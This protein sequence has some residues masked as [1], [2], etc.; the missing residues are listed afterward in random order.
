MDD[1]RQKEKKQANQ[2]PAEQDAT[3]VKDSKQ[4]NQQKTRIQEKANTPEETRIQGK[5]GTQEKTRVQEKTSK[6]ETPSSSDSAAYR[7]AELTRISNSLKSQDN[8]Q[9]FT[10]ARN[11][12]N[13]ALAE[14]KIILN[15]RFVLESTIGTGGMGTVYKA[16]DLRK[17]EANDV[18][19]N[20]AVKVLN[21]NFED[22]PDAF[23]TLQR[24]ASRSHI[25]SHPNIV[26]V[27]D[28]D[29]DGDVIYMTMELMNG[30]AMDELLY[31]QPTG[32]PKEQSLQIISDYCTLL[33]MRIKKALF[34][35]T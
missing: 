33:P 27:H 14:N 31:E 1:I 28:F 2:S 21:S 13:K 16:Q 30:Q 12:A 8:S 15:K 32:L 29:R 34:I 11:D 26:T 17:V 23:V 19:P 6:L 22:H 9:G 18:N 3:V 20:V 24:E 4:E 35:P 25:L 10:K 5:A 7:E